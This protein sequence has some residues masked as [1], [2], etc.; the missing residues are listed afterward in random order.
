MSLLPVEPAYRLA[1]RA[2]ERRWL[3]KGLWGEEAVGI[4][5]GN[6]KE[7]VMDRSGFSA[8]KMRILTV[9]CFPLLMAFGSWVVSSGPKLRSQPRL[10]RVD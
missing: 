2:K 9:D 7:P 5:G 3:V 10:A 1:A 6:E 8:A 4:V